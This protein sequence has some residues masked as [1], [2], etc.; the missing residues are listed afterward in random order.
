MFILLFLRFCELNDEIEEK[1]EL[2]RKIQKR[3]LKDFKQSI[4]QYKQ[5]QENYKQQEKNLLR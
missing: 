5:L 1:Y 3:L 4:K 2:E